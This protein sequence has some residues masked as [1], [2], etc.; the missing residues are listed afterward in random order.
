MPC[1]ARTRWAAVCG[2]CAARR[3][4]LDCAGG[5]AQLAATEA[6]LERLEG[7]AWADELPPDFFEA[8]AERVELASA[9]EV[10]FRL[11]NGLELTERLV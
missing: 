2:S 7:A 9:D 4:L 1:P 8:L 3:E 5:D 11:P 6:Q 10:R